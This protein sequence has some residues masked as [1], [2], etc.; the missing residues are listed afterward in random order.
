MIDKEAEVVDQYFHDIGTRSLLTPEEERHLA[1][2][3]ASGDAQAR[4]QFIEA[5]L[6]LVV[7]IAKRYQG[8]G[9]ALEDLVQE[10]NIGLMRAVER[11]DYRRGCKFSTY[12]TWWI[13][14]AITRAL[15]DKK[16]A[17]RL[18][19]HLHEDIRRL[20]YRES[21]LIVQLEREPT[22]Q[23]LADALGMSLAKVHQL[24]AARQPILSLEYPLHEDGEQSLDDLL[25]ELPTEQPE[26]AVARQMQ[27]EDLRKRIDAVLA[28]CLSEREQYVIRLRFGLDG[29][30]ESR[31]L[32][33]VGTLL[34]V[35]RERVRQ[36]E[37]KALS[38]L[39]AVD[40]LASLIGEAS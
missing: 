24:I 20:S 2:R 17:I 15:A 36:I 3:V 10:G 35:T 30:A 4:R 23:E 14:Q 26:E 39:G 33:E 32:Q 12:A 31:T 29:G 25:A 5:N 40:E 28:R 7:S 11:F 9:L 21:T 37:E 34:N 16:R 18:P 38:K 19:V 27:Q 1:Q 6:K 22:V 13:R 8:Q